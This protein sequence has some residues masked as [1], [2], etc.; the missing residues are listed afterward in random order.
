MCSLASKL[1]PQ[2]KYFTLSVNIQYIKSKLTK[3]QKTKLCSAIFSNSYMFLN[4]L[5]QMQN[6]KEIIPEIVK[7]KN[8]NKDTQFFNTFM[9]LFKYYTR[10]IFQQTQLDRSIMTN[11]HPNLKLAAKSFL[12]LIPNKIELCIQTMF[13]QAEQF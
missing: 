10:L 3:I 7:E 1:K 6:K 13:G 4:Q 11:S 2:I 5:I 9:L 8:Y 12:S